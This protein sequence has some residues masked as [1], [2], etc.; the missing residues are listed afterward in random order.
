MRLQSTTVAEVISRCLTNAREQTR[1]WGIERNLESG[2][3]LVTFATGR[4]LIALLVVLTC[5]VV[6][7]A[8]TVTLSPVNN[9]QNAVDNSPTGTTFVLR[10][11]T[12]RGDSITSLKDG[13]SFIGQAGADMN[14][15]K[16]LTHWTT[17]SIRGVQYWTTAGGAP[18]YTPPCPSLSGV[19]CQP[20]NP[21]CLYV[22]DLYVD[23]VDYR[24]VTR[25]TKVVSGSWYYAFTSG[26]GAVRNNIYMLRVDSPTSHTV[27]LGARNYA[28]KDTAS[29]ITIKN[30]TIEKYAAP[31]ESGAV[32]PAGSSWLIQNNEFRL[33]HG[34]GVKVMKTGNNVQVLSN[35]LHDNGEGGM[36]AGGIT[37]GL[38]DSNSVVHNNID[39]VLPGMEAG[40]AKFSGK[41]IMISNNIVHDNDGVGLHTD[42]GGTYNTYD[43]NTSYQNIGNGIR[44]EISRYGTITNNVVYGNS[45][46]AEIA[47]TGSDHGR[48]S[49]NIVTDNGIG[50]ISVYNI[51]GTRSNTR[52]KIYRVTDTR[53][54]NNTI[55]IANSPNEQAA[56]LVDAAQPRQPIVFADPTNIWAS[57]TYN[58]LTLPWSRKSWAWGESSG[59]AAANPVGWVT[60]LVMHPLDLLQL[61]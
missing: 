56:G 61:Q 46:A 41:N 57:N 38:F 37:G 35:N 21:G 47:Y 51:V 19:C 14:G 30:L 1:S 20:D 11:G 43:H 36:G 27:E 60:W 4:S 59:A 8:A 2:T 23:N 34:W 12:Y 42:A 53:V 15:A 9:I 44:Y 10:S 24:H 26:G 18:L 58:V 31:L 50:G 55:I 7:S 28:F 6:A 25:L 17:V 22:Q 33:N 54:T 40:G 48:I 13:D 52:V 5:T 49:G 45:T 29:N 16:L 32:M 39:S 3:N